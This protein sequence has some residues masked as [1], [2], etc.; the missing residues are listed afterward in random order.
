MDNNPQKNNMRNCVSVLTQAHFSC[1]KLC[2]KGAFG[3]SPSLWKVRGVLVEVN[4]CG[5]CGRWIDAGTP[6]HF[7]LLEIKC[8]H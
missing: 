3:I 5:L 2:G 4:V 7:N 8:F 1:P 6:D